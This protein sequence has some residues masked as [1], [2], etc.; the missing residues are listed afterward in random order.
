MMRGSANSVANVRGV[1]S[2]EG[3]A[4]MKGLSSIIV[5]LLFMNSLWRWVLQIF[6]RWC[7]FLIC[8]C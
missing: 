2:G 3:R 6:A 7:M 5:V 4:Q 8:A 1:D